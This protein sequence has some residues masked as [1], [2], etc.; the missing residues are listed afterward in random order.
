MVLLNPHTSYS[1]FPSC[2][3]AAPHVLGHW[4]LAR[5]NISKAMEN[6]RLELNRGCS[7]CLHTEVRAEE[8]RF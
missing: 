2:R 4:D 5:S 3:E 7:S 8:L 1:T 6:I